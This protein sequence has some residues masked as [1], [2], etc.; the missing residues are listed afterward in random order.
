[1][2]I[3]QCKKCGR[4]IHSASRCYHCGGTEMVRLGNE[5]IV[6]EKIAGGYGRIEQLLQQRK[7]S[8]VL[9]AID[10]VVEWMPT[11]PEVYWTKLLAKHECSSDAELICSGINISEDSEYQNALLFANS[12]E[13]KIYTDVSS[14]VETLCRILNAYLNKTTK[15]KKQSTGVHSIQQEMRNQIPTRQQRLIKIWFRISSIEQEMLS[16]DKDC[17]LI[18]HE[19]YTSIK[20]ARKSA[21]ASKDHIYRLEECTEDEFLEQQIG[22]DAKLQSAIQAKN[23]IQ[24]IKENHPWVKRFGELCSE[25]D[26]YVKM[27]QS[28]LRDLRNYEAT[29]KEVVASYKKVEAEH[30]RLSRAIQNADIKMVRAALGES[31]FKDSLRRA[32][33]IIN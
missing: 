32:G 30:L 5:P 9:S 27:L 16:L 29:I 19:Y 14:K 12:D 7:Y 25:R 8:E 26:R 6:H 4:L 23:E 28:E 22:L 20:E 21:M 3:V 2:G 33:I 24:E 18:T 13:N 11:N 17:Q 1:M 15:Q 31:V 10:K